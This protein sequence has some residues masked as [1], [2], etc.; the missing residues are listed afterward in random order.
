MPAAARAPDQRVVHTLSS[1]LREVTWACA[2]PARKVHVECSGVAAS[3]CKPS[4]CAIDTCRCVEYWQA[5]GALQAREL[6]PHHSS[7]FCYAVS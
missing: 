6:S 5:A 2:R 1:T 3:R 7:L 4:I